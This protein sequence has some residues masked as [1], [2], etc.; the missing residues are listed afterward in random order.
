M[1]AYLSTY[2]VV[3]NCLASTY[4]CRLLVQRNICHAVCYSKQLAVTKL[5]FLGPYAKLTDGSRRGYKVHCHFV[6][7]CH[8]QTFSQI[9]QVDVIFIING[10]NV[11][12][13]D[14]SVLYFKCPFWCRTHCFIILVILLHNSTKQSPS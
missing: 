3:K 11:G 1:S 7:N 9:K 4:F 6:Y 14:F 10:S 13:P 8:K 5:G 2:P 12:R